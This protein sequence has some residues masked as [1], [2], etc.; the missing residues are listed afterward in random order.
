MGRRAIDKTVN[1]LETAVREGVDEALR[2]SARESVSSVFRRYGL[3]QRGLKLDTFIKYARKL[4]QTVWTDEP[5]LDR[6]V[7]SI[8]EIRDK[9]LVAMYEQAKAGGMKPHELASMLARVQEHD[10]ISILQEANER[11][12]AKHERLMEEKSKALRAAVDAQTRSGE[13]L[14]RE[15]VYDMVDSVMRG[16]VS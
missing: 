12:E 15:A 4:R 9:L 8:E 2:S 11:A 13:T 16:T 6:E 10:R 14:T 5:P 7:P 3:Q 1:D